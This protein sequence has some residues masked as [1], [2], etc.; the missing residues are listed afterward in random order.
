MIA[1]GASLFGVGS[2]LAGSIRVPAAFCGIFG[3]KPTGGLVPSVGHIPYPVSLGT[4]AGDYITVG[5]MCR[6]AK[7]LPLILSVIAGDNA[8]LLKFDQSTPN[9]KVRA[10]S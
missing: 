5:P 1:C 8:K 7:D 4:D 9:L 2:D 3:H 6:Y 10:R